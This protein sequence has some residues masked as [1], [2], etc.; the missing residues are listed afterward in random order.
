MRPGTFRRRMAFVAG[1]SYPVLPLGEAVRLLG[2]G[3]LPPSATV[4]TI[5][6]GWFGVMAHAHGILREMKF[7]YTVYVTSYYSEHGSPI[8]NLVVQYLFRKSPAGRF[9]LGGGGGP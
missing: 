5:D 9:A 6:D 8:F 3:R 1:S 4:I 7:P 2:E